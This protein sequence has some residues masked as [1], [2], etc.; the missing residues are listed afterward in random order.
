MNQYIPDK[1]IL[2]FSIAAA[3]IS[4]LGMVLAGWLLSSRMSLLNSEIRKTQEMSGSVEQAFKIKGQLNELD[5]EVKL[6]DSFFVKKGE[7]VAF[8]ESVEK[9]ASSTGVKLEIKN[10]TVDSKNNSKSFK[11]D[12][13][14]SMSSR[15]SYAGIS[16]FFRKL[17]SMPKLVS[18]DSYSMRLSDGGW[19][20]DT[21]IM[22]PKLK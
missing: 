5:E 22:V 10:I 9:L 20:L 6:L 13:L 2:R 19:D 18:V 15:G 12:I 14:V 8:I 7:E 3:T 17:E 21:T 4:L 16:S 1:K 11:E